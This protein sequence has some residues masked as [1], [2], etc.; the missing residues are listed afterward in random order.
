MRDL[1]SRFKDSSELKDFVRFISRGTKEDI[2]YLTSHTPS[3]Q[4]STNYRLWTAKPL[5]KKGSG[6]PDGYLNGAIWRQE[7]KL[8]TMLHNSYDY[9]G[10]EMILELDKEIFNLIMDRNHSDD[11]REIIIT[12]DTT[13]C[14]ESRYYNLRK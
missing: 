11:E 14:L 3:G 5:I 8:K 4:Q 1:L 13:Y 2:K 10:R 12:E 7:I 6:H 9:E